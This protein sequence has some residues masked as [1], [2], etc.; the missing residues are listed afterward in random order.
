MDKH[1]EYVLCMCR[2]CGNRSQTRKEISQKQNP[3]FVNKYSDSVYILYG[4]DITDDIVGVHP[5]KLCSTCYQRLMSSK[6]SGKDGE[7]NL[8]GIYAKQ[9]DIVQ[10]LNRIWMTHS[11]SDCKVCLLYV[12]QSQPGGKKAISACRGRPKNKDDDLHFDI[13]QD[14]IFNHLFDLKCINMDMCQFVD[15]KNGEMFSCSI[16]KDMFSRH[17]VNA[18]CHYF[19]SLCLS[20]LFKNRKTNSVNCPVCQCEVKYKNV[21][22]VDSYFQTALSCLSVICR[23]CK[24]ITS[25]NEMPS[26]ECQQC[27]EEVIHASSS[28]SSTLTSPIPSTPQSSCSTVNVSLNRSLTSPLSKMEEKIHTS[29]TRQKL[30]QAFE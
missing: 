11:D 18:G 2:I 8:T 7:M 6:K 26:H 10:N 3:K 14:N 22:P 9:K 15:E 4:V 19:C 28:C 1:Q 16:C 5:D 12:Q 20:H 27:T 29:L 30:S 21:S 24:K 13:A 25:Y 17:T 23:S